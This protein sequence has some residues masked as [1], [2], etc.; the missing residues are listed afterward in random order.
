WRKPAPL[1]VFLHALQP[2]DVVRQY[3]PYRCL[4][5]EVPD[6]HSSSLRE[7]SLC[8]RRIGENGES[9]F[10]VPSIF[11]A[12]HADEGGIAKKSGRRGC[13]APLYLARAEG[14]LPAG[15]RRAVRLF[16]P[17]RLPVRAAYGPHLSLF[18]ECMQG[19]HYVLCR[20]GNVVPVQPVDIDMIDSKRPEA[21]VEVAFEFF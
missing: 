10:Q 13:K 2:C 14:F 8:L 12:V 4:P 17:S 19:F 6:S 16:Y 5:P 20:A 7:E 21:F 3:K 15:S 9:V 1:C 11:V 18:Y